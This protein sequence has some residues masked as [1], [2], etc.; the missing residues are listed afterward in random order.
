MNYLYE[1]TSQRCLTLLLGL[2]LFA[3][4]S[5]PAFAQQD[6]FVEDPFTA[7]SATDNAF[8]DRVELAWETSSIDP[9]SYFAIYRDTV[10]IGIAAHDQ[11]SYIDAT[12]FNGTLYAYSI[13]ALDSSGSTLGTAGDTGSRSLFNPSG[14]VASDETREDD[15]YIQWTDNSGIEDRYELVRSVSGTVDATFDLSA[16]ATSYLD[17]NVVVGTEYEYCLTGYSGTESTATICDTGQRALVRPPAAVVATDGLYTDRARITWTDQSNTESGF[18]IYRDG[19]TQL[20]TLDADLTSYDDETGVSGTDYTYCVTAL[21][22][23]GASESS[24][25]ADGACDTGRAGGLEAPASVAATMDVFDDRIEVSWDYDVD[26]GGSIDRFEIFRSDD[27]T[28]VYGE[29]GGI[30]RSFSDVDATAG[31]PYGYCVQ[32]V[33]DK[34]D[35]TGGPSTSAKGCTSTN[36]QRAFVLAPTEITAT[37]D[38]EESVQLE[39]TNASSEVMLFN[40]YRGIDTDDAAPTT[41]D[42][43]SLIAT[44]AFDQSSYVDE[45]IESDVLYDYCVSAVTFISGTTSSANFNTPSLLKKGRETVSAYVNKQQQVG[46]NTPVTVEAMYNLAQSIEAGAYREL[47]AMG[48]SAAALEESDPLCAQGLRSLNP[49]TDVAVTFDDAESHV[50][51]TWTD[52]SEAESGYRVYRARRV[53]SFNG[54]DTIID[55]PNSPLLNESDISF[56]TVELEFRAEDTESK[57]VL[58]EEGGSGTGMNIYIEEGRLYGGVWDNQLTGSNREV[59]PAVDVQSDTWYEVKL[60]WNCEAEIVADISACIVEL[61][62]GDDSAGRGFEGYTEILPA[63]DNPIG[64]GGVNG[65]T[66]LRSDGFFTSG[67]GGYFTG[68]IREVRIWN[69]VADLSLFT[70]NT[71]LS[72]ASESLVAYYPLSEDA[73]LVASDLSVNGLDASIEGDVVWG[74][75]EEEFVAEVNGTIASI[76]DYN[77]IPGR[78]YI[79]S[80]RTIDEYASD[81]VAES[82]DGSYANL[83][84]TTGRRFLEAPTDLVATDSEFEDKVI[85]SWTDNSRAETNYKVVVDSIDVVVLGA[86]TQSYTFEPDSSLLGKEITF[87]VYAA[88]EIGGSAAAADVG[89]TVLFPPSSVNASEVYDVSNGV[90]LSWVDVSTIEDGYEIWRDQTV[91]GRISD[92][93]IRVDS[94]GVDTTTF[95]DRISSSETYEYCVQAVKEDLSSEQVCDTGRVSTQAITAFTGVDVTASDGT[96]DDRI[97]IRWTDNS[98]IAVGGY[99]VQRRDAEGTLQRLENLD[100]NAKAYNDF[101]ALPGRAYEYCVEALDDASLG[102]CTTG[103]RPA[104]G[105]ITGRIATAEGGGTKDV[106]I[107]LSPDPN[108]ALLFDGIGSSVVIPADTTRINGQTTMRTIEAWFRVNDASID[109]RKQVIYEEGGQDFGFNLYLYQGSLY[110]GLWNGGDGAYLNSSSIESGA[111]HHVALVYDGAAQTRLKL[112][113]NGKLVHSGDNI[114]PLVS[115]HSGSNGI[116]NVSVGTQFS[117]PHGGDYTT[118]DGEVGDQ[119]FAGLIDEV[120]VWE[121]AR[122]QSDIQATMETTLSGEEDGLLGYWPLDQGAR[123]VAPDL[124]GGGANGTIGNGVY[125]S[126]ETAFPIAA[127]TDENGNYTFTGIRYGGS[128]TTFSVSPSHP[129]RSFD[130]TRAEYALSEESPIQNDVNFIDQSAFTV[131]GTIVYEQAQACPVPDV[132]LFVQEQGEEALIAGTSES[133]GSYAVALDPS[134]P[135]AVPADTRTISLVLGT[136][137]DATDF[138]PA[139]FSFVAEGDTAGVDFLYKP[140]HTI[141]GFYGGSGPSCAQDIGD[142]VLTITT[143]N[144]CYNETVTLTD[145]G[146]FELELPPQEYLIDMTVTNVPAAFADLEDDIVSFFEDLGTQAV[147]LTGDNVTMDFIYHAPLSI[148]ISGFPELACSAS[149]IELLDTDGTTVLR[150]M[151]DAP[152]IAQDDVLGLTIEVA[153]DYGNGTTC[154][155]DEGT[156]T[157]FDAVGDVEDPVELELNGGLASYDLVVGLPNVSAGQIVDGLDRS[158]QKSFSVTAEV[159]GLDS[160]NETEWV[161]VE[162]FRVRTASFVSATTSEIPLMILHDP[163]GSQSYAYMEEGTTSCSTISN[164]KLTSEESGFFTDLKIGAKAIAG[165]GVSVENG[166]GVLVQSRLVFGDEES[167]LSPGERNI[168]ICMTTTEEFATS[169]DPSAI[170]D[171]IYLGVALNLIFAKADELQEASCQV[172]RSETLAADLDPEDAFNTTYVY[173]NSF[174]STVMIPELEGLSELAGDGQELT[175]DLPFVNENSNGLPSLGDTRNL[176]ITVGEAI[177]NWQRH[178]DLNALNIVSGLENSENRSFSGGLSYEYSETTDTTRVLEYEASVN[179]IDFESALGVVGTIV[180]YDQNA[181][182]VANV[183][184]ET[185][186]ESDSTQ[187]DSRT[188]GWVFD[189]GDGQDFFSVDVG[190][191]PVY[192]T[193]V[194]G[195]KSGRTSNPCEGR[196]ANPDGSNITQCRDNPK[197]S[198]SPPARLN[199][200]DGEPAQFT[201]TITNDSESDEQR[202]ISLIS[203]AENNLNGAIVKAN[204]NF[205]GATNPQLY[206][207][208]AGQSVSVDVTVERPSG[209]SVYDFQDLALTAY[210]EDEYEIWRADMRADF[211]AQETVLIRAQFDAPST[212]VNLGELDQLWT[213]SAG[214]PP[215]SMKLSDYELDCKYMDDDLSRLRIG[216]EQRKSGEEVWSKIT[217]RTA[218]ELDAEGAPYF[219]AS[220]IPVKDGDYEVR[221]YTECGDKA[222]RVTTTPV[223]GTVDLS[224][225][226]VFAPEPRDGSLGI[227]DVAQVVFS[228]DLVCASAPA[229][230]INRL[231]AAGNAVET[232]ENVQVACEENAVT[233][234]PEGGWSAAEN[235]ARYQVRLLADEGLMDE[236]GNRVESDVTWQFVIQRAEFSFN[237]VRLGAVTT[238]GSE[239][240]LEVNLANGKAEAVEFSIPG[241]L[242]LEH[243][244]E[245]GLPSGEAIELEPSVRSGSIAAE[246]NYP[247]QFDLPSTL[248]IGTWRGQMTAQG[249]H[250][251]QSLGTVPFLAEVE[252]ACA[253]PGWHIG[254]AAFGYDMSVVTELHFDGMPSTSNEDMLAAFVGN[255]LRGLAS[256]GPDGNVYLSVFSNVADGEIVTFKAWQASTCT[257]SDVTK[258]MAFTADAFVDLGGVEPGAPLAQS[259]SM[260]PGWS[261]FSLNRAV[262]SLAIEQALGSLALAEGDVVTSRS[263]RTSTYAAGQ[264]NGEL[265]ELEL[266]KGYKAQLAN[267]G[268]LHVPGPAA[269]AETPIELDEGANW[270]G[271]LPQVAQPVNEALA[272]LEAAPG[273]FIKSKSAFAQYV[274]GS[275]WIGSLQE[276]EP[277]QGYILSRKEAGVLQ[278]AAP[279]NPSATQVA[280]ANDAPKVGGAG[281]QSLDAFKGKEADSEGAAFAIE[282]EAYRYTMMMTG[283][284]RHEGVSPEAL[285]VNAYI[286]GELRG[287]A[288]MR[289]VDALGE[290]RFFLMVYGDEAEGEEV[291]FELVNELSEEPIAIEY[292]LAFA[293]DAVHGTPKEPIV[294]QEAGE[295]LPES[296]ELQQNYPNPFNPTTTIRYALPETADVEMKVYDV[297][298][299]EVMTLVRSEQVAAGRYE[300]VFDASSLASGIYMYTIKAGS[301]KEVRKMI[302]VK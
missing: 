288:K 192:G 89:N 41:A 2:F 65:S 246:A 37:D 189:D 204:G 57:Q 61:K 168:E 241:T 237:P 169:D 145:I 190:S 148:D 262:E 289:Y 115:K 82:Q 297:L 76:R 104:N 294:V 32:A 66:K 149:G 94:I 99:I 14:I 265:S 172:T 7:F 83:S 58:Y 174:I 154:A 235:G 296:Y 120:R 54:V 56:R 295:E 171:D 136:S 260:A 95:I 4:M 261:W 49:P 74:G 79:Y 15:I 119:Y 80:V 285:R 67:E 239:R 256:P 22:S 166:V 197:I 5:L 23:S 33:S 77:G 9:S 146:S 184:T 293:A 252:V 50:D 92:T 107:L 142:L 202:E 247:V 187:T 255:R 158:F 278:Y 31:T 270:I 170:Q 238:R 195:L 206:L 203:L 176:S 245:D 219:T 225:P 70:D 51:V 253:A 183:R 55:V 277:G 211:L 188:I 209:S 101:S 10:Q 173:S 153:E 135:D 236:M 226:S 229:A 110:G 271:Y 199:V 220:W 26:P 244:G 212:G 42:G 113:L 162:G 118:P 223:V 72:G 46:K 160:V 222:N 34:T 161:L 258:S 207:I 217:E 19:T 228:E 114:T 233:V 274:D 234:A 180:G 116:G 266:G 157:I 282:E 280:S 20:A 165:F 105:V 48:I 138:S 214:D 97:Q 1:R 17:V 198:V 163:P 40:I 128:S 85:L 164:L 71:V 36:G 301:F 73:G 292:T 276:M 205:I 88:D 124:T 62:A 210:A 251:G 102:G 167:S 129:I 143:E 6:S 25:S 133:D 122:E 231:D 290:Y 140:T 3:G 196:G 109:T 111:W 298:G 179:W 156:I 69:S 181:G 227:G 125:W 45:L 93:A 177:E 283:E 123:H 264:W 28:T 144:G 8:E 86:N 302:L 221:A 268:I 286:E 81:V 224:A 267:G 106:E 16:N 29:T 232:L 39:W 75:G 130:R 64:I 275:G 243:V 191:D 269:E 272:N 218:R 30:A 13:T 108:K 215:L 159:E 98:G 139:L 84:Q 287:S 273:D 249:T 21:S 52:A 117:L 27:S 112:Y 91:D 43:L 96:Y 291:V 63:H 178:L 208:P 193:P 121:I 263:G 185:I 141:S 134:D 254:P 201:V 284:A 248:E 281:D 90:V 250:A 300:V 35:D 60:T 59:F 186:T 152:I 259:I 182:I 230:V 131:S 279:R 242:R 100:A 194:F 299:R 137:S 11:T 200:A 216:A 132:Q 240:T 103:W 87:S 53:L 44:K 68:E 18:V 175:G 213:Y 126:D 257:L 147:D 155:V 150:T 47:G 78:S 12:A 24:L 151:A 38:L 127:T